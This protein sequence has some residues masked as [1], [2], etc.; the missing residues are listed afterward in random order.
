MVSI[1]LRICSIRC[2]TDYFG[3]ICKGKDFAAALWREYGKADYRWAISDP[4]SKSLFLP[5]LL[6]V[7]NFKIVVS[8]MYSG[9]VQNMEQTY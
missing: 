1:D 5:Q 3:E 9:W 6:F 7:N 4:T 2:S 8:C